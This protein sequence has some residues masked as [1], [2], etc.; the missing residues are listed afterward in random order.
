[1]TGYTELMDR[2]DA[3]PPQEAV[4]YL[5]SVV[6]DIM[7][8][9]TGAEH[10]IDGWAV[11][12]TPTE[13]LILVALVDA[14]GAMVHGNRLDALALQR[15]DPDRSLMPGTCKVYVSKIRGKLPKHYSK[16][17]T[18]WGRGYR[19]VPAPDGAMLS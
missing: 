15:G 19:F 2:V 3:M 7:P 10:E 4:D 14:K 17:E 9:M 18:M 16:I 13:R 6:G 12:L 1:M 8:A 11:H 5:L